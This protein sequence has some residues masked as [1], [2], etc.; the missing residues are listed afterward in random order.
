[1]AILK[2]PA[3]PIRISDYSES[4]VVAVFFTRDYGLVRAICKGAKRKAK[5]YENAID[6][7]TFGEMTFYERARGLNILKEYAPVASFPALHENLDRYRAALACVELVRCAAVEGEPAAGLFDAF[8]H[9][10][11]A[12]AKAKEPWSA[13][14]TFLVKGLEESGFQPLLDTCAA[15]GSGNLPFGSNARTAF[16]FKE[17]GVL[18][19]KCGK[20]RKVEMWLS[21]KALETIK[22]IVGLPARKIGGLEF[23]VKLVGE[24]RAFLRRYCE[25][26]FEQQFKM[27]N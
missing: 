10:I 22:E 3:T 14:Y 15:C 19:M 6:L 16:S 23:Q 4:S 9:A 2:S 5:A 13:A 12:C 27:L 11:K 18:C 26:T 21:R 24:L 20:G 8:H 17:G 7:L 25:F 1:M